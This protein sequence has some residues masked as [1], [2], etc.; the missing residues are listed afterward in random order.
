MLNSNVP[1]V[2]PEIPPSAIT[3][4]NVLLALVRVN[5]F[6]PSFTLPKPTSLDKVLIDAPEVVPD[7]SNVALSVT[8]LEARILPAPVIAK[9]PAVMVVD[10]V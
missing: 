5:A 8:P 3:P 1:A 10:P 2:P 9:V 6:E 7:I 4:L